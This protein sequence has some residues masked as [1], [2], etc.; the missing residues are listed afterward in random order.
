MNAAASVPAAA[1]PA[2]PGPSQAPTRAILAMTLRT[3]RAMWVGFLGALLAMAAVAWVVSEE[4]EGPVAILPTII[5]MMWTIALFVSGILSVTVSVPMLAA[6]GM[7]RQRQRLGW[8]L[9]DLADTAIVLLVSAGASV[10]TVALPGLP[11]AP[12]SSLGPQLALGTV[13]L[14]A[15][16]GAG[17]LTGWAF[18]TLPWWGALPAM[19]APWALTLLGMA[20]VVT[21]GEGG[22]LAEASGLLPTGATALGL[23]A[24]VV[25]GYLVPRRMAVRKPS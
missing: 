9:A 22:G 4:L 16:S 7:T 11:F 14:L 3:S 12:T 6:A 1:V 5:L 23:L 17:K 25:L 8:L 2:L 21:A 24:L 15:A 10:L 19:A 13:T 20:D 18:R